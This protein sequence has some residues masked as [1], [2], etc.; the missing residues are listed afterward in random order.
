MTS[1]LDSWGDRCCPHSQSSAGVGSA[2]QPTSKP[3][4]GPLRWRLRMPEALLQAG[5]QGRVLDLEGKV[6]PAPAAAALVGREDQFG[7]AEGPAAAQLRLGAGLDAFQ[8][9]QDR[10]D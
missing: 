6:D 10:Q 9:V 5:D 8:E 2:H 3:C 1:E 7:R 4:P